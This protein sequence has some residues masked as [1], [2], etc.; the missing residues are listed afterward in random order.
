MPF[1]VKYFISWQ[2]ER[3]IRENNSEDS[4]KRWQDLDGIFQDFDSVLEAIKEFIGNDIPFYT[5]DY[6]NRKPPFNALDIR[7][8]KKDE[9]GNNY[10]DIFN[11][12]PPISFDG[13]IFRVIEMEDNS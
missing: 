9:N 11:W 3:H 10:I 8:S 6:K 5:S 2:T 13:T 1:R 7:E 4:T 12:S